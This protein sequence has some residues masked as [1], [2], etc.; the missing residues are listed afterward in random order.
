LPGENEVVY[1]TAAALEHD[2]AGITEDLLLV[3]GMADDNVFLRHSL[4]MAK[5]LQQAG[6]KF[7]MML[8]PGKTHLIAGK[9]TKHHLYRMMFD[10]FETHLKAE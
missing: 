7:D 4:A 8:Y 2:P 6:V 3:H 10:F 9:E 5:K 1:S